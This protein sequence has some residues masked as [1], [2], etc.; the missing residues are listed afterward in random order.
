MVNSESKIVKIVKIEND[1]SCFKL[2]IKT[3][4]DEII[5]LGRKNKDSM[6]WIVKLEA[7][8]LE[9]NVIIWNAVCEDIDN[10]KA[11]FTEAVRHGLELAEVNLTISQYDRNRKF[12][13]VTLNKKK[14]NFLL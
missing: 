8:K 11:L 14:T 6:C 13:K 2:K 4:N 9:N 7:A 5:N 1:R 12:L 10:V 3:C